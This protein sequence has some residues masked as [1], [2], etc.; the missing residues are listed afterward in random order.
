MSG[1]SKGK[2][3]TELNN[4]HKR[5]LSRSRGILLLVVLVV[6]GTL[7][8]LVL[9]N[10]GSQIKN[11]TSKVSQAQKPASATPSM[12]PKAATSFSFTAAGDYAQTNYTTDNLHYIAESKVAFNLGLGDFNYDPK[13]TPGAWSTYVKSHLP[14]N[15]PF[16]IVAGNENRKQFNALATNLPN[17]IGNISGTYGEEYYFDYP[18]NA[19]LARFILVSPGDIISGYNYIKGDAHYTWVTKAIDNARNAHI[20]WVIV[21]MHEYC[22]VIGSN[23]CAGQDLLNLL[24][25]KKVD[26]ILQAHKHNYQ[27]SKQ[28]ALNSTTCTSLTVGRYNPNC[29]VNARTSLTKGT[30]STIVITGTGGETPLAPIV[31]TDPEKGYFRTWEGGNIHPSWGLSQFTVSAI[32]ISMKFVATPGGTFTDSFTI[33]S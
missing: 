10:K 24:L 21:G 8:T 9:S 28:L 16:E 5:G 29:V 17:H 26:L 22:I 25:S 15:F 32:Q 19:P 3:S 33:S 11:L 27:V 4:N 23:P 18:A 14:G 2:M 1:A 12:R 7:L 6:A 13:V 20:P 30:G 31:T